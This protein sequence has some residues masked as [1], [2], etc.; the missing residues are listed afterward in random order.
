MHDLAA[1]YVA[2]VTFTWFGTPPQGP[3]DP[4][5]NPTLVVYDSMR[6]SCIAAVAV[7]TVFALVLVLRRPGTV[8]QR[9]R[10]ASQTGFAIA[11]ATIEIEHFGDYANMRL[12]FILLVSVAAAWGN[13]LGVRYEAPPSP[14]WHERAL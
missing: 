4:F 6:V 10:L 9:I 11:A 3:S 5:G 1:P 7:S 2:G 12:I 13:Y 14:T 8:G